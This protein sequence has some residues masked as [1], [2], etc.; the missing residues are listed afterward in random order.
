MPRY[1]DAD[2]LLRKFNIDDMCTVNECVPIRIARRT[3]EN[4]PTADVAGVRHGRWSISVEG[5][6][7]CTIECSLCHETMYVA[8]TGKKTIK[9]RYTKFCPNCGAKMEDEP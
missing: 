9:P 7:F 1:I 4:A 2:A 5:Y 3:I 6:E 8:Y